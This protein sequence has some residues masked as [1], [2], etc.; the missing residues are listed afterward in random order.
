LKDF[1]SHFETRKY[2]GTRT[3]PES[4]STILVASAHPQQMAVPQS[5]IDSRFKNSVKP[6]HF[7][8]RTKT[9]QHAIP[10]ETEQ[11][12]KQQTAQAFFHL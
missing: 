11:N 1:T 3:I 7:A 6:L 8:L 9:I 2:I 10:S 5:T 4:L 12:S